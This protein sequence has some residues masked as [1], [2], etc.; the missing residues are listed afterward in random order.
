MPLLAAVADWMKTFSISAKGGQDQWD[1]CSLWSGF[2]RHCLYKLRAVP[3]FSQ[4]VKENARDTPSFLAAR[5]SLAREAK[6]AVKLL[7]VCI[8]RC[9]IH[10]H[11][12]C[13]SFPFQIPISHADLNQWSFANRLPVTQNEVIPTLEKF[14]VFFISQ[15]RLFLSFSKSQHSQSETRCS[16]A[17]YGKMLNQQ[18]SRT[19]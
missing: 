8:Q 15:V 5:R 16:L 17:C 18:H 14:V 9:I 1:G 4:S 12:F 10:I 7:A 2:I 13:L 6:S 11:C 19:S 3:I